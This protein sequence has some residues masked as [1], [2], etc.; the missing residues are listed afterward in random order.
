VPPDYWWIY[1]LIAA[2]LLA[3]YQTWKWLTAP[4]PTF[5]PRL[6]P[7]VSKVETDLKIEFQIELNPDIAAGDY[8]VETPAG[9]IIKSE[10]NSDD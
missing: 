10:R 9:S 4:R 2:L 3:G 6:D 7:G 1:L 8:G 5:H